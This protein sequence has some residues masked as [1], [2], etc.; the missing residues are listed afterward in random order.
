MLNTEAL[1]RVRQKLQEAVFNEE[2]PHCLDLDVA[3]ASLSDKVAY[4]AVPFVQ[5]PGLISELKMGSDRVSIDGGNNQ[6]AAPAPPNCQTANKGSTCQR[7]VMWAMA[8][9]GAH[10]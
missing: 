5:N 4:Y 8:N 2:R 6:Q 7:A 1:T 10:P 9:V 3:L